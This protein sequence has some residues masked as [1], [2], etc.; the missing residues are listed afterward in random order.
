MSAPAPPVPSPTSTGFCPIG[1]PT[2]PDRDKT[3]EDNVDIEDPV[4]L[5][6]ANRLGLHPATVCVKWAVQRG[7]GPHPLL[8]SQKRVHSNHK[9]ALF[10]PPPRTMTAIAAIDKS[11]RLIKGQ[12]FLWKD[13]ESWDALWDPRPHHSTVKVKGSAFPV[14]CAGKP[15]RPL[16]PVIW[17]AWPRQLRSPHQANCPGMSSSIRSSAAG[18][19]AGPG[20]LGL[21]GLCEINRISD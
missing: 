10:P 18:E 21:V 11:C 1:S 6:I 9:A 15:S 7:Q 20:V 8:R 12:V 4:I 13:G 16:L 14:R 19:C 17:P 3:P 2:R 5:R